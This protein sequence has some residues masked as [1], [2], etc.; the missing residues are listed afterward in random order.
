[1]AHFYL[2]KCIFTPA[3]IDAASV[4]L[5]LVTPDDYIKIRNKCQSLVDDGLQVLE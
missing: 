3:S 5:I 4:N 1:M 2:Y